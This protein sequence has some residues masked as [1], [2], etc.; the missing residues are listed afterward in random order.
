MS[1]SHGARCC[2]AQLI[3]L[4]SLLECRLT[5]WIQLNRVNWHTSRTPES[6][7]GTR[8]STLTRLC[9]QTVAYPTD[10]G[11][12]L[13]FIA[14]NRTPCRRN[15]RARLQSHTHGLLLPKESAH[16]CRSSSQCNRTCSYKPTAL[17]QASV[18]HYPTEDLN[19]ADTS[20]PSRTRLNTSITD[21]VP[22][23]RMNAR[24]PVPMWLS[25]Q[26]WS[27]DRIEY[28]WLQRMHLLTD[29]L[30]TATWC[31]CTEPLL[32]IQLSWQLRLKE[33]HACKPASMLS[34]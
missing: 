30:C 20:C 19:T 9:L 24:I 32:N 26:P 21:L 33:L 5:I 23:Q 28:N 34:S 14:A 25:Q 13:C 17:M 3:P 7:W 27:T 1:S 29:S 2:F 16:P 6:Q 18:Q 31:L 11:R 10:T 15:Q 4:L 12:H 8:S 22:V